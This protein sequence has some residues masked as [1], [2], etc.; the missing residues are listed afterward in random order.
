MH[1]FLSHF[2]QCA[3][4]TKLP[5]LNPDSFQAPHFLSSLSTKPHVCLTT[6]SVPPYPTH[7]FNGRF[8][9]EP[10]LASCLCYPH[11]PL[12]PNLSILTSEAKTLHTP[13]DTIPRDLLWLSP[14][15][16]SLYHY[17]SLDPVGSVEFST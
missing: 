2:Q 11:S 1:L 13:C 3:Q 16:L 5:G 9:G 17:T 6:P 4:T 15:S 14:Q 10:V 8:L 7:L 12:T